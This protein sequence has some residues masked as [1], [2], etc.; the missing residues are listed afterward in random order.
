MPVGAFKSLSACFP[1]LDSFHF[2]ATVSAEGAMEFRILGLLEARSGGR[3][4]PL[5]GPRQRA[6]LAYLL[7]R[8]NEVVSPQRLLEDLWFEL[9]QGGAAALQTQISRLRKVVGERL[10][11]AGHSYSLRVE[12]DELDLERLRRLLAAAGAAS[13]PAE[14]SAFLRDAEALWSGEPLAGIEAPFVAGEAAALEELRY[15][16]IEERLTAD[17][18]RGCA[19]D[20]VAEIALLVSQQPLRERLRALQMLTLYRVGRQAEA[21]EVYQ[22][23]RAILREELGLEPGPALREL[24]Q[25]I[26]R[27]DPVLDV[28]AQVLEEAEP[29]PP[30][31]RRRR[32]LAATA[33][34]LVAA[35]GAG[36]AVL[37]IHSSPSKVAGQSTHV[38]TT[39]VKT[40]TRAAVQHP[41]AVRTKTAQP[42]VHV[43][44]RVRPAKPVTRS[45]VTVPHVT[46]PP[47]TVSHTRPVVTTHPSTTTA[48]TVTTHRRPATIS[49][50]FG[51][52]QID[53]TIWYQ[54]ATG[55]G[56][57]L[58]QDNGYVEFAF[59]A[60]AVPG[61]TYNRIGGHLGS[62]CKFP[63]DFDAHVDFSLPSW[64]SHNGVVVNL[65]A[66][67]ANVGY[68]AWR[69]SSTQWGE[70][71]G[72]YT[73]PGDA[74]GVQLDDTSGSLRL[75]RKD[76]VLKAYFMHKGN[77]NALTSTRETSLATIAIGADAGPDFAGQPV[78]VDLSNFTVTGDSPVC[79]PGSHPTG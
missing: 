62:Q 40:T 31:P 13:S 72:S 1:A 73:G 27:Q 9:P 70:L 25:A 48:G 16:A 54:I 45:S 23:A 10:V 68:A 38:P 6:L 67:F 34:V 14:R 7:L 21:L 42:H 37:I 52:S 32:T 2:G 64:P 55:T 5:G 65:W 28:V 8:A 57:T 39:I 19:A 30:S 43:A 51:G 56:W 44:A 76:G 4:L 47:V 53:P 35:G 71:F 12:P 46:R 20:L 78:T 79:P 77:W 49:D 17:L 74:G 24:Q 50:R 58:T 63:G 33:L 66:F 22:D 18:E 15:G 59:G 29:A 11:S 69:Q 61:G 3:P 26:L 75:V 36:A 60:S 41:H